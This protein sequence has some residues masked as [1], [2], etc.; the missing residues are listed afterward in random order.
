MPPGLEEYFQHIFDNI[1]EFYREKTA[2]IFLFCVHARGPMRLSAFAVFEADDPLLDKIK[3][4]ST[5]S[6][7]ETADLHMRLTKQIN[8]RCQDLL[9]VVIDGSADQEPR[10]DFLHRTVR[11][12]LLT[13]DMSNLLIIR[14]GPTFD[15]LTTL[16]KACMLVLRLSSF[17]G[18][19]PPSWSAAQGEI[20]VDLCYYARTIEQEQ[21]RTEYEL[22]AEL[23][24]Y[25]ASFP[26]AFVGE[27]DF[28]AAAVTHGLRLFL[29]R[30]LA[31]EPSLLRQSRKRPLLDRAVQP[32]SPSSGTSV[33]DHEFYELQ[34]DP[35]LV[36]LLVRPLQFPSAAG[37]RILQD[38]CERL[39]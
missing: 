33:T 36:D 11:D 39:C 18:L 30:R 23:E 34:L 35:K 26:Q 16:C 38:S 15:A 20:M 31:R 1:E 19:G 32:S 29:E 8:A 5:L 17:L 12:F 10:A 14:A 37:R 3:V 2:Q 28:I 22:L 9:E 25:V 13:K 7:E 24:R 4:G 21:S 27:N 6:D